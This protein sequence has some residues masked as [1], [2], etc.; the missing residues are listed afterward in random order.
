MVCPAASPACLRLPTDLTVTRGDR[1]VTRDSHRLLHPGKGLPR[2]GLRPYG[3]KV[4]NG[5]VERTGVSPTPEETYDAAVTA[6]V[7][8]LAAGL[9][10]LFAAF[11]AL[12]LLMLDGTPRLVMAATSGAAALLLGGFAF[13]VHRRR[14]PDQLGHP[15]TSAMVLLSVGC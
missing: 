3:V 9:G 5:H 13:A 7:P 14:L 4:A 2:A 8:A 11:A 6:A 15:A 12:H 1:H 10:V